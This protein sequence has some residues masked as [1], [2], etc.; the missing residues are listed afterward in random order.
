[1]NL[2]LL[3][4]LIGA[5]GQCSRDPS[6]IA[7]Q[8]EANGVQSLNSLHDYVQVTDL[9]QISRDSAGKVETHDHR[10]ET[11]VANGQMYTRPLG[12][13]ESPEIP[14]SATTLSPGFRIFPAPG[15]N[16]KVLPCGSSYEFYQV[17]ALS[18]FW[19]VIQVRESTLNEAPAL[20]LDLRGKRLPHVSADRTGTAW[21]EP[22]HCRLLQLSTISINRNK[23][24]NREEVMELGEVKGSWLPLKRR[25]HV[26]PNGKRPEYTEEYTYTYLKFGSSTRILP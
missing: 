14:E 15:G 26:S 3:F 7:S 25:I 19:D 13:D 5:T 4:V 8:V 18:N 1:M 22:G 11:I 10:S 20:V 12:P 17:T 23:H 9:H 16:C 24:Q 21:V 6:A 2:I